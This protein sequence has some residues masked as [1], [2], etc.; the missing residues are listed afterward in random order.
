[1]NRVFK[2]ALRIDCV[3]IETFVIDGQEFENGIACSE[4]LLACQQSSSAECE[5][6][7]DRIQDSCLKRIGLAIGRQDAIVVNTE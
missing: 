2:F 6:M 5:A 1:M 7:T 4:T 3:V